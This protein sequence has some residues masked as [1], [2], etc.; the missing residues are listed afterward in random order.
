[1]DINL[2]KYQILKLIVEDF[3]RQANPVGSKY[4]KDKYK[5]DYSSATIRNDMAELESEG[6]LE[7]THTSSGRVPSTEGYK[8]YAQN[9]TNNT[10]D[11]NFKNQLRQIFDSS[12][13]VNDV[14]KESCAILSHMTNLASV[15]L[16]PSA[17]NE[18]LINIQL[19]PLDTKTCTVIFIT[20]SGY[21]ENKTFVI[22]EKN[23]MSDLT[24]CIEILDERLKGTKISDLTAKLETMKPILESYLED[25]SN[26][27]NALMKVFFE[28]AASRSEVIGK[29]NLLSQPEFAS[30]AEEIKKIYGLF[31]D[32]VKL[33]EIINKSNELLT[34]NEDKDDTGGE[35]SIVSKEISLPES[36]KSFGKIAVIGP[37]RMDYSKVITYLDYIVN[38]I[39]AHIK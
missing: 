22:T 31:D 21:V 9:F 6:L 23:K 4:L 15:V 29:D 27:Y 25:Y 32:P 26:L 36:N 39:L 17:N 14:L 19:V 7:K 35:V 2:R 1:M 38:E 11:N 5:L 20:D 30:D 33:E 37:K 13:S 28:F 10:V 18:R 16:G 34:I 8:F 12:K 24:K 3:I